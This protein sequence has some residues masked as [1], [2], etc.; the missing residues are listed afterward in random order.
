MTNLQINKEVRNGTEFWVSADAKEVGMSLSGLA[1][2]THEHIGTLGRLIEAYTNSQKLPSEAL[3]SLR[4]NGLDIRNIP[5]T[6]GKPVKFI[7]AEVCAVIIEYY[8]FEA[9]RIRPEVRATALANFR[10]IASAGMRL[11]ILNQVGYKV[12]NPEQTDIAGML[13][14]ILS[15]MNEMKALTKRY[16][17][18]KEATKNKS[19]LDEI[20]ESYE[21]GYLLTDGSSFSLC[22]WLKAKG[23]ELTHGQKISLGMAVHATFKTHSRNQ[24]PVEQSV[25]M[26]TDDDLPLLEAALKNI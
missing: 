4:S 3:E 21:Q 23:L 1:C 12:T 20:L 6:Q 18:I 17:H 11:F 2:M 16:V 24:A 26:Y 25:R 15:E 8:A 7:P 13:S 14:T 9:S 19:G 10:L 22:T 5:G